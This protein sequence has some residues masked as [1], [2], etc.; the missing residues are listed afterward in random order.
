MFLSALYNSIV[1]LFTFNILTILPSIFILLVSLVSIVYNFLLSDKVVNKSLLIIVACISAI[2]TI[3][4]KNYIIMLSSIEA[5]SGVCFLLVLLSRNIKRR[6]SLAYFLIHAFAGVLMIVG[7]I[8]NFSATGSFEI[9]KVQNKSSIAE[10]IIL[11]SLMINTA[12]FPFMNWYVK[13]YSKTDAFSLVFLSI[14]TTKTSFFVLWK[15]VPGGSILFDIGL[16]TLVIATFLAFITTN[17]IKYLLF[18]SIASMGFMIMSISYQGF[19]SANISNQIN[20]YLIWYTISSVVSVSGFLVLYGFIAN[21]E[22]HNYSFTS[23]KEYFS[24]YGSSVHFLIP[25]CIFGLFLASFPLTTSFIAKENIVKFFVESKVLYL[26][27]KVSSITFIMFAIK[28][29]MPIFYSIE[30]FKLDSKGKRL[31]FVLYAFVFILFLT[32][33]LFFF[34][35]EAKYSLFKISVDFFVFIAYTAIAGLFLMIIEF[36]FRVLMVK[37]YFDLVTHFISFIKVRAINYIKRS[38]KKILSVQIFAFEKANYYKVVSNF[39]DVT[40]SFMISSVII[41]LSILL[42]LINNL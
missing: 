13:T 24:E 21:N 9:A 3:C 16:V 23:L 7:I 34:F 22:S 38:I 10:I 6:T 29:V 18:T 4:S 37:K 27:L 33:A 1:N 14:I 15:I 32:N 17:V 42:L 28:L 2:V 26:I 11:V 8:W 5:L 25:A 35:V 30:F 39:F 20:T 40:V 36:I 31:A 12:I 41:F 19:L